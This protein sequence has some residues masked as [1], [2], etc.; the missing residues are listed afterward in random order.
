MNQVNLM[1]MELLLSIDLLETLLE[2]L[3]LDTYMLT[4]D[5]I[6]GRGGLMERSMMTL[7]LGLVAIQMEQCQKMLAVVSR[8]LR[9]FS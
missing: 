1:L 4:L 7:V 9:V 5:I 2:P 6:Q 8:L 3:N